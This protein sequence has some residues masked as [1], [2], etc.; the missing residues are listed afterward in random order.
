MLVQKVRAGIRNTVIELDWLKEKVNN[1]L[2]E[3]DW[4]W[5]GVKTK[6]YGILA[7][8]VRF[9]SRIPGHLGTVFFND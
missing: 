2:I 1:M 6:P 9:R 4:W 8:Q 3:R 5:T 7:D